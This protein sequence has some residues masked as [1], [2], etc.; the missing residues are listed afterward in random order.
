MTINVPSQLKDCNFVLIKG[1]GKKP[2]EKSWQNKIH[3]IND[4]V[5]IKH[6]EEGNNY[7]VQSNNSSVIIN[8]Q[9]YFLIVVDFD[10]KEFQDIVIDKFPETFTTT[11]GSQK[12]CVHLWLASDNN[13]PFKIK[14]EKMNSLADIIGEGN[15][16]IAVGS[17]HSSGSIY[18]VVKDLPI[19]FMSYAEIEAI[20][21]PYD[22][23]PKKPEKVQKQF[24]PK[25]TKNDVAEK[26]FDTVSMEDVLNELKI[27]TSKNPT[28]CF[29]HTSNNG[30]CFGWNDITAHCFHCD[31][32]WNKFS[33]IREAKNLS[34]KETFD[35]F[36]D[37]AGMSE[38]LK[39][40][41]K[42]YA[43]KQDNNSIKEKD[44]YILTRRGQVESY[45]QKKPFYYDKSKIFWIWNKEE[46]KWE[47]SDET[48]L[49]NS[50]YEEQNV[51]TI[52]SKTKNELIEAFKQIGRI[53]KPKQREKS[54]VQFKEKIYDVK[55]GKIF[56]ASP[57]YFIVNPIP[58][59]VGN[60]EDTPK[61]DKLF[62]D[63]IKEQ[64]ISWKNTLYEISAYSISSD[65]FMQRLFSLCGGGSNGKGTFVKLLYKFLGEDN[66][67]TSEIKSLSQDKFEAAGL[68]GKLL[69]VMGEV[70]Y[71]DLKNT[72]QLKKLGGED[73]ISFQFKGKDAFTGDNTA[74]CMCLTNSMPI[75]PD[76]T[77]GFYRKWL[78]LD[79][80][81]QFKQID[82]NIIDNIPNAEFEN[83]A[84]KCLR[85]LKELYENPH[86]T[87][88]GDF[89][90]RAKRYEERSNPVLKF[91]EE[92]C[93]ENDGEFITLREFTN[94]CNEYLKSKHLRIMTP[95]QVGKILR[96]EGFIVGN[97]KIDD[98]SAVVI[99]NL[100]FIKEKTI[101]TIR[102]INNPTRLHTWEMS[103]DLDSFDSSN[104][105]FEVKEEKIGLSPDRMGV[106]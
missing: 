71:D 83:F 100:S 73:K 39:S 66:C 52:D 62:D 34:D 92:K 102:T 80:H 87:N 29:F 78:I 82:K 17:K 45:W 68:F 47:K 89:D 84:K 22:R 64:D 24:V 31:K 76:K 14:D 15:Q 97:R 12:Q 74:T 79:F 41:R 18:S 44:S 75:T 2:F 26:I 99:L 65:K 106:D 36:A 33:L 70:S 72:N 104:S 46:Y 30:Q 85:I 88:E 37:K 5:L 13:K 94:L 77:K 91:I 16:V 48:E 98:I 1:D 81:N 86:F 96:D 11:S 32:S 38:E 57:E 3:R 49:C 90:E 7:G 95:N 56:D 27:D 50:I 43:E 63:W 61:I 51:D 6:L 40:A 53:H 8:G 28:Q 20:L 4:E 23:S 105:N 55:T 42:E 69:C 10:R 59:K 67:V 25:G 103:R 93:V 19:V 9:T 21:R 58:W 101:R 35:W 60:N 54:W